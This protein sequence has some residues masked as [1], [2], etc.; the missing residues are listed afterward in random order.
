MN[1]LKK[2][3][4]VSLLLSFFLAMPVLA[5]DK[6][7]GEHKATNCT[8]CH[9]AKG[10]GSTQFP[11]LAA[12]Q[13]TYIVIQLKAFKAAS[14]N[15]PIMQPIAADLSDA[16]MDNLAAYFS[17]LPAAKA[18]GDATLAKTA[19][20]KSAMCMGCHGENGVGNGQFPRLAGQQPDYL[21][22]QLTSFKEGSRKN[23]HMQA[24][25]GSISEEDIKALAAY[26]GSL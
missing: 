5:V 6:A 12:Q 23:G 11:S 20:T 2:S 16:D 18:G 8:G 17:S 4:T 10:E 21:I 15:S 9:G 14:R 26:F 22:K 19:Q 25:A 13:A 7:A 3:I 1:T 24:I